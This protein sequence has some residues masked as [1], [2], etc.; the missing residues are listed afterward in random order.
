MEN[1]TSKQGSAMGQ[2]ISGSSMG[3]ESGNRNE[4]LGKPGNSQSASINPPSTYTGST[5]TSSTGTDIKDK[6]SDKISDVSQ[7]FDDKARQLGEAYKRFAE[8]GRDY[9]RSSPATSLLV[10]L[11]AGYGLSK[12]FGSRKD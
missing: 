6:V 9:V 5:A 1:H 10:A 3:K 4:E 12:L 8:T 11:A 2:D 7:Q